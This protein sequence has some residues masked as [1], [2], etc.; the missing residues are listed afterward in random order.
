VY[1]LESLYRWTGSEEEHRAQTTV[2]HARGLKPRVP[3]LAW[4]LWVSDVAG[5]TKDGMTRDTVP[6]SERGRDLL[7]SSADVDPRRFETVELEEAP[8]DD[9]SG[10]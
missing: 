1:L 4:K 7:S 8:S 10:T 3:G 6:S 5:G 2:E 9:R